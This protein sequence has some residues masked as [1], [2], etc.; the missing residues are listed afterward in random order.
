MVGYIKPTNKILVA[1]TP[2]V[3]ELKIKTVATM[4]PGR[5]VQKDTT[6]SGIKVAVAP[7]GKAFSKVIGILG[8]EQASDKYKPATVDTI[9]K[10][11]DFVPV[12]SGGCVVVGSLASGNTVVKGDLL[13]PAA[14]GEVA[15]MPDKDL[16]ATFSDTEAELELAQAKSV[17]AVAE[18]SVDASGGA[19]DIMMRLIR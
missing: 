6:D 17:I 12:L 15:L 11:N 9:Y 14:A 5:L 8:Y 1:G 10:V 18:E 13:I 7:A 4:Y 19:K 2:L 16:N 3:Q